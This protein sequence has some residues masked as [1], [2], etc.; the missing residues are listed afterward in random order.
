MRDP[1]AVLGV[2]PGASAD[3]IKK[4]Y[5][6]LSRM[7]HPDA[8]INNPNKERAEEK[9]REVQEAYET[10]MDER[11][12]GPTFNSSSYGRSSYGSSYGNPGSSSYGGNSYGSSYG[13]RTSAGS[14]GSYTY[15]DPRGYYG[16]FDNRVNM[17]TTDSN[18]IKAAI[19]FINSGMS[20]D[21][22]RVLDGID[23]SKHNARWYFVRA[24]AH[25]GLGN[26][27]RARE[28]A[29]TAV[30][31]EPNNREYVD[32]FERLKEA[33]Y[34]YRN[35]GTTYGRRY[36]AGCGPR[37]YCTSI[38]CAEVLCNI[39]CIGSRFGFYWC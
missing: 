12:N 36:R 17:W 25:K 29:F 6:K 8:N 9:F 24:H 35:A 21:A 19:T 15:K 10:I 27:Y 4:A 1:Y 23:N 33:D 5:R 31:L 18:E 13:S 39:C 20:T 7:Y 14:S 3:E 26:V 30:E 22:L 38:I 34:V 28:D 37:S 2:N 16:G 11:E 32:Y